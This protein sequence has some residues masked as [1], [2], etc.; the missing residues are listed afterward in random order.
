MPKKKTTIKSVKA[1]KKNSSFFQTHK[2]LRWLL[3]LLLLVVVGLL[4]VVKHKLS[5]QDTVDRSA[6]V[7]QQIKQLIPLHLDQEKL[8]PTVTPIET[9]F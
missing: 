2:H 3:P 8:T 9:G 4:F 6:I 5:D 1:V 7:K